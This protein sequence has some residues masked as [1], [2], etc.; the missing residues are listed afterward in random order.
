MS[1]R[2]APKSVREGARRLVAGAREMEFGL[3]AAALAY[4]SLVALAPA[5]VLLTALLTTL[6]G[7]A[8]ATR[9]VGQAGSLLSP[10]GQELL[11]RAITGTSE[12]WEASVASAVVLLWGVLRLFR[13]LDTAMTEIYRTDRPVGHGFRDGVV[14]MGGVALAV[15]LVFG[16]RV[17]ATVTGTTLGGPGVVVARVA[18]VAVLLF[19][20][21][22][23]LPNEDVS[24]V[25]A[26]PGTLVASAGWELLRVA[27]GLYLVVVG[28]T[29][30]SG[31][32]GTVVLFVTWLFFG[33]GVVLVG[34]LVNAV[35]AGAR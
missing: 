12:A 31:I 24:L 3:T 16:A 28:T 21:Y 13:G 11:A 25:D 9:V 7:D 4:Y 6:W 30:V 5:A 32:F 17:G 23:V 14:A 27:F 1:Q 33:S 20:L 19:P 34:G 35:L 22:Y 2:S 10:Q 26:L 15:L 18:V 8:V 29:T